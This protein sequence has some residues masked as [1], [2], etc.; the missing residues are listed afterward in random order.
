MHFNR[1]VEKL[2]FSIRKR[3]RMT[4]EKCIIFAQ[5]TKNYSVLTTV[6]CKSV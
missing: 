4:Y 1:F 2:G 3:I 5:E 6:A